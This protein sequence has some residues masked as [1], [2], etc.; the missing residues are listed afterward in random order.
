MNKITT[1]IS[2]FLLTYILIPQLVFADCS[3]DGV[4]VAESKSRRFFESTTPPLYYTCAMKSQIRTCSSGV[5]SGDNKYMYATCVNPPLPSQPVISPASGTYSSPREV[6][7]S[8][9]GAEVI[10]YSLDGTS[11]S[12]RVGILYNGPFVLAASS[13][14][15]AIACNSSFQGVLGSPVLYTINSTNVPLSP[16]IL[17]KNGAYKSPAIL[18]MQASSGSVIKYTTDG[19]SPTCVGGVEYKGEFPIYTNTSVKAI[20]CINGIASKEVTSEYGFGTNLSCSYQ[21]WS[22]SI[23]SA[24]STLGSCTA[25]RIDGAGNEVKF[26]VPNGKSHRFYSV[27]RTPTGSS[28]F[29]SSQMRTC[30]NGVLSGDAS[31]SFESCTPVQNRCWDKNAFSSN[32]ENLDANGNLKFQILTLGGLPKKENDLTYAFHPAQI[33]YGQPSLTM[34]SQS[35]AEIDG[36]KQFILPWANRCT[37]NALEPNGCFCLTK[38]GEVPSNATC[39][40]SAGKGNT[41]PYVIY[42]DSS[43]VKKQTFY[44]FFFTSVEKS[45]ACT[46]AQSL[47]F[48]AKASSTASEQQAVINMIN[49][50]ITKANTIQTTSGPKLVDEKYRLKVVTTIDELKALEP[51]LNG[52]TR[53]VMFNGVTTTDEKT[54]RYTLLGKRWVDL[55][56][57]APENMRGPWVYNTCYISSLPGSP[58]FGIGDKFKGIFLDYEVSDRRTPEQAAN[59][60]KDYTS[61]IRALANLQKRQMPILLFTDPV[62]D[63]AGTAAGIATSTS[64]DIYNAVDAVNV[65]LEP[66]QKCSNRFIDGGYEKSV[67]DQMSFWNGGQGVPADKYK[68]VLQYLANNDENIAKRFRK[69]ILDNDIKYVVFNQNF[70]RQ[71]LCD[72]SMY[73]SSPYSTPWTPVALHAADLF[74]LPNPTT[75]QIA[76]FSSTRSVVTDLQLLTKIK[77]VLAS[78]INVIKINYL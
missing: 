44:N 11:P 35:E 55:Y 59:F 40:G 60:I 67:E 49:S 68:F 39:Y 23:R 8:S 62:I 9:S 57:S 7:I 17:P 6:T 65:I 13:T 2:I 56:Q 26:V 30:K 14:V 61:Q 46:T 15:S 64:Q 32:P 72:L 19:T 66:N 54:K 41:S 71:E 70:V 1:T 27:N 16:T 12:C 50:V 24:S 74:G 63:G 21:D 33:T 4:V 77:G 18:S 5:L 76:K 45:A 78:I 29:Q 38:A 3:L 43:G 53:T 20:T 37:W 69:Y 25:I 52:S 47:A 75:N 42:T 48:M 31:Y 22:D 51:K 36:V 28:C 34:L 58:L 73:T 10:R